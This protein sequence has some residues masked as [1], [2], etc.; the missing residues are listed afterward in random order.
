MRNNEVSARQYSNVRLNLYAFKV[1]AGREEIRAQSSN[2]YNFSFLSG[3]AKFAGCK[4]S[5]EA[6]KPR[7]GREYSRSSEKRRVE[8]KK[9]ATI[10]RVF[11]IFQRY[12]PVLKTRD[13][14]KSQ[15]MRGGVQQNARG[16]KGFSYK[17]GFVGGRALTQK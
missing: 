15:T 10:D 14:A 2:K 9:R 16:I 7:S 12:E 11:T 3:R 5:M 13:R 8:K 4:S 17:S 6:R 1:K